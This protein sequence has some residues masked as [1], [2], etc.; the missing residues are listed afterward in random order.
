MFKNAILFSVL[1]LLC[2]FYA[3]SNFPKRVYANNTDLQNEENFNKMMQVLTHQRCMNCHP[4][5]NAPKQ[6]EERRIHDFGITRNSINCQT[7]HQIE[8]N[9][10][11]GIPG[12]PNWKMAP[13]SM[14]W[15]GLSQREIAESIL[16]TTKNGG[17]THEE[18][19]HHL[20]ED[21]LVLWAW[22]PGKNAAGVEREPV[23]IPLEEFKLAVKEWFK[24]GAIIPETAE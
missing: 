19:M 12:A 16:D 7:C 5:G 24:N 8:N 9:D 10:Y 21:A 1:L 6:G 3:F 4:S 11:A 18:I 15:E 2:G 23:P 20:T 13:E 14:K 22:N 17:R